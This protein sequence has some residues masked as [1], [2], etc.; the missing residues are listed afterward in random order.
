MEFPSWI[1]IKQTTMIKR[2]NTENITQILPLVQQLNPELETIVL[3]ERLKKMFLIN[4]YYCFGFYT[5]DQLIGITSVWM[6]VRLYSGK[7]I[8]IDNFII[9]SSIQSKGYGKA[10]LI[11]LEAWAKENNCNTVELNTYI[12]NERSHKFYE[13]Q[14]YKALGYHFQ[15]EL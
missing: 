3:E 4:N 14:G 8:E 7:Q 2:L 1:V 13:R 15:K 5:D 11:L 12:A 6:T 9:D 10:F